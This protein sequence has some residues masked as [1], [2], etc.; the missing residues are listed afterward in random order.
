[1]PAVLRDYQV[2][3]ARRG[4]QILLKHKCLLD[5]S[6]TGTGKTY[7][8]CALA[9]VRKSVPLVLAPKATLPAWERVAAQ[10]GVEIVAINPEM[11]RGSRARK[12]ALQRKDKDGIIHRYALSDLGEEKPYGQG[13]YWRWNREFDDVIVDEAHLYG[14]AT[15]LNSKMLIAAKRQFGNVHIMTGTLADNPLQMK[16]TGYALGL[17]NLKDYRDFLYRY[18]CKPA[19]M[20]GFEF[21]GDDADLAR[22]HAAIFP[23]K[24]IRL[25]KSEIP[26][27]PKTQI[28][29]RLLDPSE[30]AQKLVKEVEEEFRLY[31]TTSNKA[32]R[33]ERTLVEDMADTAKLYAETS[34]VVLF[35]NYRESAA[36]LAEKLK[37][38]VIWGDQ[39]PVERQNIIDRFQANELEYVV[40]TY[41]A[42]QAGIGFHDPTGEVQRT[43]ELAPTFDPRGLVQALGRVHRDGAAFS[44][45][46]L[47]GYRG[48]YQ[49]EMLDRLSVK[50]QRMDTINGDDLLAA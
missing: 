15:T 17:H 20:G 36:A 43:V 12:G 7:I 14:G 28:D 1:M 41:G 26:G 32:I 35:V 33:L 46:L 10:I 21:A 11:A 6:D 48:T 24:G 39:D 22:L 49:E 19:F 29:V 5:A 4:L 40:A 18:G 47:M 38:P 50:C 42:G 3:H 34:R 45:Q 37:C 30:T 44:Q 23:A 16:A 2:P 9:R 27:F 25:R 8:A 13:S 31:K